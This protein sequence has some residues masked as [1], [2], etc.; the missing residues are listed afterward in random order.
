[1][2]MSVSV[3]TNNYSRKPYG[4]TA[5]ECNISLVRNA[6]VA[7]ELTVFGNDELCNALCQWQK[8]GGS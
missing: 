4:R 7:C 2:T 6:A 1:M 8:G 5:H 3:F